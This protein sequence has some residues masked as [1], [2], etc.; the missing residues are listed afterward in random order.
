MTQSLIIAC[1]NNNE[2][3][4]ECINDVIKDK[5]IMNEGIINGV[6]AF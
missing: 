4:M 6:C 2:E 5:Q 3:L 1:K